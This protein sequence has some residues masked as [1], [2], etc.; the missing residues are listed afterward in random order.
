MVGSSIFRCRRLP[1][2]ARGPRRREQ[3]GNPWAVPQSERRLVGNVSRARPREYKSKALSKGALRRLVPRLNVVG[4]LREPHPGPESSFPACKECSARWTQSPCLED[5][6]N[7]AVA[8]AEFNNEGSVWLGASSVNS[9]TAAVPRSVS[10]Q[11]L[12]PQAISVRLCQQ[13]A[14]L[15]F[16]R[17]VSEDPSGFGGGDVNVYAFAGNEPLDF[18]DQ[19]GLDKNK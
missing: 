6:V 5:R 7:D 16:Q 18:V 17:F 1:P 19:F 12:D 13:R 11:W 15:L 3:R 4:L 8:N 10:T 2:G 9:G 14:G